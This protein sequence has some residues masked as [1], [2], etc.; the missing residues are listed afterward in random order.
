M[1]LSADFLK[2]IKRNDSRGRCLHYESGEQCNKIINAHSI[3]KSNQLGV[4]AEDGH[5]YRLTADLSTMRK[6]NGRPAPKRVG[7]KKASTFSGFCKRH[8]N[9]LFKP[10]DD[11]L[12]EPNAEQ[13]ALYA[14]RCMCREFFVKQ[15][16]ESSMASLK[17]HPELSTEMR[18]I[19]HSSFSGHSLGFHRLKYHKQYYD[20]ALSDRKFDEF[21]YV[22][23]ES[24]SPWNLQLSGVLYPDYD[25]QGNKLQD[26][27]DYSSPL[28]LITFF[29][30]PTSQGWSFSMCWHGSS[31][32]PCFNFVES[33][34]SLAS[35]GEKF[36]DALFRLSISC[37]DNH[38]FKVSWW[39]SLKDSDKAEIMSRV[40]LVTDLGVPIPDSYLAKGLEGIANWEFEYIYTSLRAGN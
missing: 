5:V 24:K 20:R 33:L 21:E 12:L 30:A 34:R 23:F 7:V 17:N 11:F 37:C 22:T 25:F 14:Y 10:I 3:Q 2:E 13:I 39:D 1:N 26:L 9:E 28:G 4:I 16:A 36:Q 31:N 38:A 40:E 18:N 32:E 8:D 19:L 27:G 35:N 29:T 6:N 15:N